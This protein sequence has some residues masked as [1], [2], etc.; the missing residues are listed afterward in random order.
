MK[1]TN[2]KCAEM[3]SILAAQIRRICNIALVAVI[4]FSIAACDDGNGPNTGGVPAAPTGLSASVSGQYWS[5]SWNAVSGASYY[6][7]YV[8]TSSSF[9]SSLTASGNV[10][11]TSYSESTQSTGTFYIRVTAWNTYGESSYSNTVSITIGGTTPTPTPTYSI[12]GIWGSGGM[13]I[14]VTG[15]TG[16]I[17]ALN[18]TNATVQDAI[19]KGYIHI[20]DAMW[21]NISSTGTRTWSGQILVINRTGNV[22]T[23]VSW[24]SGTFSLSSDGNTLTT[25]ASGATD[26]S[27][28]WTRQ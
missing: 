27:S 6:R 28:T 10:Y 25:Y 7:I 11:S 17:T 14:T 4:G 22:A 3:Q 26:P 16:Y 2:Y 1:K 19:S 13:R 5:A 9:P 21:R 15:S 20:G 23:G 24:T 12:T 18:S 8:S